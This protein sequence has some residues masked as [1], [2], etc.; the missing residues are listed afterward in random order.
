[1]LDGNQ[2]AFVTKCVAD[3]MRICEENKR[4]YG[5]PDVSHSALLH[6]LL[7]GKT[8]LPVA[9][10]KTCSYPNYS[11]GEGLKT[12]I[13]EIWE[14]PAFPGRVIVDQ[15]HDWQWIDKDKGL[16]LH[17]SS[18]EKYKYWTEPKERDIWDKDEDG[19]LLTKKETY[20]AKFVQKIKDE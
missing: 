3:W 8:A 10:P 5:V 12:E 18:Q 16:L 9:P 17:I 13:H 14:Y 1:M 4:G 7:S 2:I 15:S 20:E 11:M 6:R 19:K